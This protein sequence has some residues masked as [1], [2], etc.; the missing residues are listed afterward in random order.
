MMI[1]EEQDDDVKPRRGWLTTMTTVSYFGQPAESSSRIIWHSEQSGQ[2]S[3]ATQSL[4]IDPRMPSMR[5]ILVRIVMMPPGTKHGTQQCS[6]IRFDTLEAQHNGQQATTQQFL[7]SCMQL[8]RLVFQSRFP[9]VTWVVPPEPV[10]CLV[11]T[12][13]VVCD[14]LSANCCSTVQVRSKTLR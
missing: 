1:H 3:M 5:R 13:V 14:I 9:V 6:P 11:T 8:K 2:H 7:Q 10:T 12:V 4:Q